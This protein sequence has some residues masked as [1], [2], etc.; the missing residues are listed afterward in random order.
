MMALSFHAIF[1]GLAL[2]LNTDPIIAIDLMVAIVLHKYAEGMSLSISLFKAFKD[3]EMLVIQL[4]FIFAF[5]TPIGVALGLI[6]SQAAEIVTVVFTSLAG[7]TFLYIS[8]SEVITEEF[9]M[10]GN[11]VF[12]LLAFLLGALIITLLW[13]LDRNG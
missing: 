1:E 5:A 4:L 10:P 9:S 6:L 2:G 12:K 3:R 8:C 13:F 7:G 11:R